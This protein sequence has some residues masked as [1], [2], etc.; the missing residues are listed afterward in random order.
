MAGVICLGFLARRREHWFILFGALA[1]LAP[2]VF[3]L[4]YPIPL[5]HRFLL[6]AIFYLHLALVWATLECLRASR[7]REAGPA[8]VAAKVALGGLVTVIALG[9]FLNIAFVRIDTAHRMA[10]RNPVPASIGQIV[11]SVPRDGVV[12]ARPL[13]AWPVPTF[14]GKVVSLFHP[15]PMV[16]DSAERERDVATFFDPATSEVE[17]TRIL[18]GYGVSH[19]L[20]D[21]ADTP[22]EVRSYLSSIGTIEDTRGSL[23][24]IETRLLSVEVR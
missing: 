18:R 1:M 24:L 11:Q 15:N 22:A 13:L 19:V 6:F 2:Y 20:I 3:N 23:Q 17:R 14:A 7:G 9:L 16:P 8:P 10:N 12:M 5:G 4:V 21:T